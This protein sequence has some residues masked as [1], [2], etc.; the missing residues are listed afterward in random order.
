MLIRGD[1][2]VNI[3]IR[4]ESGCEMQDGPEKNR[5]KGR[6]LR[7]ILW[8]STYAISYETNEVSEK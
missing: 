4:E 2:G 5:E 7:C 6:V 8:G 1:K 3:D